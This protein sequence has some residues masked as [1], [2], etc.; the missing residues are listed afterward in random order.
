MFQTVIPDDILSLGITVFYK[1]PK[2]KTKAYIQQ[3]AMN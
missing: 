3:I 2:I 1:S